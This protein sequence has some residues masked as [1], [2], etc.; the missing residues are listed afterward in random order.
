MKKIVI[1]IDGYSSCGKSTLAKALS[2][3]LDYAFIDTGAM[4]RAVTL[5]LLRHEIPIEEPNLVRAALAYIYIQFKNIDGHNHTFLNGADVEQEI[6]QM[7]ISEK[8]SEVAAIPAVRRKL[9]E[10]QQM[11][12]QEKRRSNDGRDIGTVVFPNAELKIFLTASLEERI[13]RR[14]LELTQKGEPVTI[15]AV[16]SNLQ[17][18]DHIDSTRTESPLRQADDAIVL[19]NTNMTEDEQLELAILWVEEALEKL[20]A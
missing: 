16:A 10:Q 17:H 6:R 2:Q 4:Y 20:P 3:R 18:R 12:G 15:E 8:V 11:M 9:V 13:N 19:D 1:A 7:R 5:Y 14:F